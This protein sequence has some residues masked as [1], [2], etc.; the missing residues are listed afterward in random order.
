[1][2]PERELFSDRLP[3]V[4][5]G[6]MVLLG[7]LGAAAGLFFL[8]LGITAFY[9]EQLSEVFHVF[10]STPEVRTFRRLVA[11]LTALAVAA[12]PIVYCAAS[13]LLPFRV[14]TFRQLLLAFAYVQ[15]SFVPLAWMYWFPS[16]GS[17]PT[18]LRITIDYLLMLAIL[19]VGLL[20][21]IFVRGRDSQSLPSPSDSH[22]LH[23][24]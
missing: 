8:W 9:G 12:L 6:V 18:S 21:V 15:I 24:R 4:L 16:R 1:M 2:Q 23:P 7:F 17:P 14:R 10:F 3:R 22:A 5:R 13:A 19:W 11:T 20:A